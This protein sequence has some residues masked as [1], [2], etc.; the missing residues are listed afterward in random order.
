MIPS[1]ET[2]SLD[3]TQRKIVALA[4]SMRT[5]LTSVHPVLREPRK[6]DPKLERR[7]WHP[8]SSRFGEGRVSAVAEIMA[9]CMHFHEPVRGH[10]VIA[11][12]GCVA[13]DRGPRNACRS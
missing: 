1:E 7:S 11:D 8:N 10:R 6:G 5:L 9:I 2:I 13:Y 4:D 3:D 12:C